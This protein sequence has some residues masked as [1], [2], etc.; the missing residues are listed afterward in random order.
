MKRLLK[1]F[2]VPHAPVLIPEIGREENSFC[3]RTVDA[4]RQMAL[5]IA[6]LKPKRIVIVGPHGVVF[7]DAFSVYYKKKIRTDFDNFT[8]KNIDR[9][10]KLDLSFIDKL[11]FLT[12]KR[13]I[14]IAKIDESMADLF[15][16]GLELDRGAG[17][18]L[19]FISEIYDVF[20]LVPLTYG[21]LPVS[22]LY[23][24]GTVLKKCIESSDKSTVF[25]ASGDLSHC[26]SGPGSGAYSPNGKKFDE[27]VME[28]LRTNKPYEFLTYSSKKKDMAQSCIYQSLC[29]LYGM[30]ESSYYQSK[31]YS[32]EAPFGVGY[33]V[34]SLDEVP[35]ITPPLLS[36]LLEFEENK[37]VRVRDS[38]DD[39]IRLARDTIEYYVLNKR[40][41]FWDRT[42]YDIKAQ[43]AGC[44]VTIKTSS[45]LRGCIGTVRAKK[46]D[47]FQ[48]IVSNAVLSCSED[49]RFEE[50]E[51]YELDDLYITVDILSEL[52]PVLSVDELDPDKFGIVVSSGEKM[53]VL[54]PALEGIHSVSRQIELALE[55]AKIKPGESYSI[56]RFTVERHEIHY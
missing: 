20:E 37:F 36:S 32:Y 4:L 46:Q 3:A 9:D 7:S 1:S 56:H 34:A 48:E 40:I 55:R 15:N 2:V 14:T 8:F 38:E 18:P 42:K 29:V 35:G 19:H 22:E 6:T 27:M 11:S 33:M 31:L 12:G 16:V 47:I 50:V 13:D 41:P 53:G 39:Y 24:F 28:T 45:G 26:L 52:E 44:F 23:E 5:E 49:D 43:K 25:L 30:F 21:L 17:V 51:D 10:Y 54:L